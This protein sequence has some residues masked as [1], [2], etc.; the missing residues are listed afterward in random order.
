ML[1]HRG[2][3]VPVANFQL[4]YELAREKMILASGLGKL[5]VGALYG[6]ATGKS[7]NIKNKQI[8]CQMSE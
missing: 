6:D 4:A 1:L 7:V 5:C 3:I 2:D 8:F